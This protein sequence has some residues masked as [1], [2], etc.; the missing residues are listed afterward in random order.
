MRLNWRT[1]LYTLCSVEYPVENPLSFYKLPLE[2]DWKNYKDNTQRN[3]RKSREYVYHVIYLGVYFTFNLLVCCFSQAF[4]WWW[5]K[6]YH[7]IAISLLVFNSTTQYHFRRIRYEARYGLCLLFTH[8]LSIYL[9][10]FLWWLMN[11]IGRE[12]F[13][14]LHKEERK[15]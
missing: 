11:W 4:L 12:Y 10:L 14:C 5:S 13:W 1:S 3:K 9:Y 6:L 15:I 7:C 8:S 2:I